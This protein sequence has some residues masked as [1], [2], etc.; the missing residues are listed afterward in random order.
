MGWN[1]V[2]ASSGNIHKNLCQEAHKVLHILRTCVFFCVCI[3]IYNYDF[4][5]RSSFACLW[6]VCVFKCDVCNNLR[7]RKIFIYKKIT[8]C[9]CVVSYTHFHICTIMGISKHTVVC[10]I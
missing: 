4:L 2:K 8:N 5:M 1:P 6:C 10:E 9:T 7:I 3:C